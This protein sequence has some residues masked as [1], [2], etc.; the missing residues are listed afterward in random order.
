M[1]IYDQL[2]KE[3]IVKI[4]SETE[5]RMVIKATIQSSK[6]AAQISSELGLPSRS[7]YRYINDLCGVGLLTRD[8]NI[9]LDGGG[10]YVLY[11]SM[12]KSVSLKYDSIANTVEVDLIPNDTILD[13]FFRFWTYMSEA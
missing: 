10:K 4:L 8:Q 2:R 7:T 9:L 6:S 13:K 1:Q 3:K 5:A 11:R 12:V